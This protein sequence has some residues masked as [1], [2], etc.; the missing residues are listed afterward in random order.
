M[1]VVACCL[2]VIAI[3]SLLIAP[4]VNAVE[5]G[6]AENILLNV[7][8][9]ILCNAAIKIKGQSVIWDKKL[10]NYVAEVKRRNISLR[11]CARLTRNWFSERI[12]T[13]SATNQNLCQQALSYD[14]IAWD[15]SDVFKN[16]VN[17]IRNRGFTPERCAQLLGRDLQIASSKN[18][19]LATTLVG[20]VS[21]GN[22]SR[23]PDTMICESA[24][25]E[26]GQS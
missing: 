5:L 19:D 24:I 16:I 12:E 25:R 13:A 2:L 14:R 21:T 23:F 11:E 20:T 7:S 26:N 6:S 17:K 3:T 18:A 15:K 10:P 4:R 1:M 9:H 8:K 22:F